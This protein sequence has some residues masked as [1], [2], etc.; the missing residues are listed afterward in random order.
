VAEWKPG[1][2]PY[3]SHFGIFTRLRKRTGESA[4]E[5][6]RHTVGRTD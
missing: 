3:A 1:V 6:Q 5:P 4:A 2:S